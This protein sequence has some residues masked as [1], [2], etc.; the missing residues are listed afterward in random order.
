MSNG[1]E[2]RRTGSAESA[3]LPAVHAAQWWS[4]ERGSSRITDLSLQTAFL[5]ASL[6]NILKDKRLFLNFWAH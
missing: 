3:L 6:L 2:V 1:D 5:G 4:V